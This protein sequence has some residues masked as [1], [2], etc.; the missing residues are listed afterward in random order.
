MLPIQAADFSGIRHRQVN[1][2]ELFEGFHRGAKACCGRV[3]TC[4]EIL[5]DIFLLKDRTDA[6]HQYPQEFGPLGPH[7]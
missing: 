6:C 7:R 1:M 3:P 5:S 4:T 2:L